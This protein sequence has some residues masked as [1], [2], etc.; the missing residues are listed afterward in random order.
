MP[1]PN[2]LCM[3]NTENLK[4][5]TV[6]IQVNTVLILSG[7]VQH[8][9]RLVNTHEILTLFLCLESDLRNDNL[10]SNV[11]QKRKH[12]KKVV[13]I[14]VVMHFVVNIEMN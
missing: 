12:R 4:S 1:P 5:A 7:T 8:M 11:Q 14:T 3:Q 6:L 9:Q 2:K 13:V 10:Y